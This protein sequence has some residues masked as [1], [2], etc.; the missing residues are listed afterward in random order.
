MRYV[1]IPKGGRMIKAML[2]TVDNPHNPFD[3]FRAWFAWDVAAG[4]H[5][6]ALLAKIIITSDELSETEQNEANTLAIDEIVEQNV[7]GMHKKI[8]RFID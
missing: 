2:T 7:T 1:L 5:S 3:N 6:T 8:T 4:Y